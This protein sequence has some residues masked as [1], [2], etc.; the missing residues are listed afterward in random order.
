MNTEI[1]GVHVE[2]TDEIKSYIDKKAQRIDFARDHIVDLLFSLT[3]EKHKFDI[4]TNINFR[5]GKAIHVKTGGFDIF[6]VIDKLFD[7]MEQKINKEKK[8]IQ[9]HKGKDSVRMGE[10]ESSESE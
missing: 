3:Q 10:A 1:K 7:K 9:D 2:I 6:E 4:E 5:W 8:K